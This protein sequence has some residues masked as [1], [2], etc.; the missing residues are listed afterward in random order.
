MSMHIVGI[1]FNK[2]KEN[3]LANN[4]NLEYIISHEISFTIS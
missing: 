4:V 1:T 2:Y 3:N